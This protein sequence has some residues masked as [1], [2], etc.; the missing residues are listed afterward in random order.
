LK[1]LTRLS[2][3]EKARQIVI[4]GR[5]TQLHKDIFKVTGDRGKDYIVS[6]HCVCPD[7]RKTT[8]WCKHRLAAEHYKRIR[9]KVEYSYGFGGL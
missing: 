6:G 7:A 4:S 9:E 2:R 8:Y 5:V 1:S 3:E